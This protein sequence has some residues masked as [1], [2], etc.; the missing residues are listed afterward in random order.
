MPEITGADVERMTASLFIEPGWRSRGLSKFW[1]LLILAALIASAGVVGDSTATVIGAMIVA[2]LMTP[3][4]GSALAFVLVDRRHLIRSVLLVVAGSASVIAVG[5]LVGWIGAPPDDFAGNSQV[6]S[7]ISPHLIDL[8]AALATGT[9][10][11]FALA[12]ADVSDALPGVAIAISLVPP[13]AVTG[14]LLEVRRFHDAGQAALLFSTNVAAIIGTGI[15]VFLI[16]Q[17]RAAAQAA[18][19]RVGRLRGTSL[20]SVAALLVLVAVPLTIG[21]VAVTRDRQ[22]AAD[23][24]PAARAWAAGHGW[25]VESVTARDGRVDITVLGQPPAP[26]PQGLRRALDTAGAGDAPLLL[27][28][29]GGA[30]LSCPPRTGQ[31]AVTTSIGSSN[32]SS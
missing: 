31:C 1:T 17:V 27:H 19:R 4:L 3:I 28:V 24:G 18:G 22:L 30:S 13:L 8:L 15:T 25:E 26:D 21:T 2:P 7:R 20:A 23:A 12:R 6:A 16:F 10:G 11:A 9:A 5:Y 29:V 14:L 32:T